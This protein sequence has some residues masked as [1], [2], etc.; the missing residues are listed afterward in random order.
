MNSVITVNSA[1]P[2]ME[3]WNVKN[4][5]LA[6]CTTEGCKLAIQEA[7]KIIEGGQE[8]A[9]VL[10][11]LSVIRSQFDRWNANL[12]RVSPWY[13]MKCNPDEMILREIAKLGC[14]FDAASIHEMELALAQGISPEKIV[15]SNPCR[16]PS[17]IR[18]AASAGIE[19]L[20]IDNI[21][22][23]RKVKKL[24]PTAKLLLRVLGDDSLSK[25]KFNEKFGVD[26]EECT[27]IIKE[28]QVLGAELVGVSFHVGSNCRSAQSFVGALENSRNTFDLLKAFGFQ[29][30][31]L[32][33]GGGWPGSLVGEEEHDEI[34]FEEIAKEVREALDKLFP[35]EDEVSIIAEPGRYFAHSTAMAI[36]NVTSKRYIMKTSDDEEEV[37]EYDESDPTKISGFRYY[38]NDGVYGT[39]NNVICD[40]AT[41][42][43]PTFILNAEGN[44]MM[45]DQD[46]P[47]YDCTVWGNTCDGLDRVCA[48][49]KLPNVPIGTWFVFKNMGAYTTSAAS[50]SF[51]GFPLVKK[52]YIN[53]TN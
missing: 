35:N 28:A 13:A 16:Q 24:H 12:P 7:R 40:H 10:F 36:V 42:L 17:H 14:G 11:D 29:P 2:M 44:I 23:L 15:F 39:F 27:H 53:A 22:E 6:L 25:C 49:V 8:D 41:H 43:E 38:V 34:P 50:A 4:K 37:V 31:I 18:F 1:N 5:R 46:C 26:H 33:L 52:F 21:E 3:T 51:N 45:F 19:L 47:V 32:D 9:F 30:K 20:T 48:S